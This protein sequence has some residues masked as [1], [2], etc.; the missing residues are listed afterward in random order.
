MIDKDL[1]DFKAHL[2]K[3]KGVTPSEI[4]NHLYRFKDK[5]PSNHVKCKFFLIKCTAEKIREDD[6]IKFMLTE[7][8]T[9]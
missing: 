5:S 6:F 8:F 4:D 2:Q 9:A 7:K 1:S 3:E